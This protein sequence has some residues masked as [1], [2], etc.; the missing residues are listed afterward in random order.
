M[1]KLLLGREEDFRKGQ[2]VMVDSWTNGGEGFTEELLRIKAI[3]WPVL[4]V[5]RLES[6]AGE[7][8][9]FIIRMEGPGEKPF[10]ILREMSEDVVPGDAPDAV[11]VPKVDDD[12]GGP[13]GE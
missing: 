11:E 5:E 6:E 2:V 10:A 8:K 7:Q 9:E 1:S 12:D 13:L 3:D 4:L